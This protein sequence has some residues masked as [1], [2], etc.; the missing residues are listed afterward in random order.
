MILTENRTKKD[1]NTKNYFCCYM[2]EEQEED[3]RPE[4]TISSPN[5]HCRPCR[6]STR[7]AV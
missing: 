1:P 7:A 5:S 2:D 4:V 6:V 3:T